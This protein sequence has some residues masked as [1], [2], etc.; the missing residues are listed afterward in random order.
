VLVVD[1]A[2]V[3]NRHDKDNEPVVFDPCDNAKVSDPISPIP[4][5]VAEQGLAEAA[6]VFG[7]RNSSSQIAKNL[8]AS[9]LA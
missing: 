4:F 6:G 3:A 2:P 9:R 7:G 1:V 5:Q 8:S